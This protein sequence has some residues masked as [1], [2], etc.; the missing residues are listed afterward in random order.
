MLDGGVPA[1]V[2]AEERKS[3]AGI[4]GSAWYCGANIWARVSGFRIAPCSPAPS[5]SSAV[6]YRAMSRGVE[7]TDDA[8][9][10]THWRSVTGVGP[11]ALNR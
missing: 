4:R 10:V 5:P 3:Q 9:A 11:R 2:D 8:A 7:Y 6:T 1:E